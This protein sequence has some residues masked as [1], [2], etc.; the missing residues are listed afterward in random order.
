MDEDMPE[1]T[2][3]DVTMRAQ[4]AAPLMSS[5]E[6]DSSL[7]QKGLPKLRHVS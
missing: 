4:Q 7:A 5:Y 1:S 6:D 2:Q 3:C